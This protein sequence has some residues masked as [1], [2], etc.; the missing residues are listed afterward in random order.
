VVREGYELWVLLSPALKAQKVVVA[1]APA[2]WKRS[3]YTWP[4]RVDC[5]SALF[6][7]E[8]AANPAKD[9][10]LLAPHRV[11]PPVVFFGEGASSVFEG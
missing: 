4:G 10:I 2:T 6:D 1:A 11:F 5:A 9:R 7:I 3:A 8:E